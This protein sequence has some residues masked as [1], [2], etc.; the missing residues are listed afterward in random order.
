M[1]ML[2]N[3]SEASA[4]TEIRE[5]T[6]NALDAVAGGEEAPAPGPSRSRFL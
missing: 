4:H 1:T 5:L 6:A 3:Q 2:N